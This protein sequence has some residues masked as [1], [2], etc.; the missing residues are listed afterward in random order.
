MCCFSTNPLP[1]SMNC[2]ERVYEL[3][4]RLQQ[5]RHLTVLLV[6]HDLSIVYRAATRFYA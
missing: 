3:V 6:S 2:E 1:V 4:E 5:E